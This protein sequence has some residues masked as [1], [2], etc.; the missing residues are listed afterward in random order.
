MRGAGG[1]RWG[2]QVSD[3]EGWHPT[4]LTEYRAHLLLHRKEG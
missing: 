4:S 3:H 1:L 2:A